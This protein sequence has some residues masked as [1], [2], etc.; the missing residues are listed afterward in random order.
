M[1]V[2]FLIFI[3]LISC[4]WKVFS[5][6]NSISSQHPSSYYFFAISNK[7]FWKNLFFLENPN[8]WRKLIIFGKIVRKIKDLRTT[9][10]FFWESSA[11]FLLFRPIWEEVVE[12]ELG[13]LTIQFDLYRGEQLMVM[14]VLDRLVFSYLFYHSIYIYIKL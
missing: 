11:R 7:C 4:P 12:T 14:L 6:T 3:F 1:F 9:L 2:L 13:S 8:F 5:S 10:L